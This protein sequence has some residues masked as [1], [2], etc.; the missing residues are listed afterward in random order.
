[1]LSS[2]PERVII[3]DKICGR[4]VSQD[5]SLIAHWEYDH[6]T[7]RIGCYSPANKDRINGVRERANRIRR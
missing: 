2:I 7:E 5:H 4:T 1:M 6:S 3:M